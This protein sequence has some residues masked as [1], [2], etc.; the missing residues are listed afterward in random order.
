MTEN[1]ITDHWGSLETAEASNMPGLPNTSHA[2]VPSP[3][4]NDEAKYS[5][6]SPP[7]IIDLT[8]TNMEAPINQEVFLMT[9]R[10]SFHEDLLKVEDNDNFRFGHTSNL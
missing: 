10:E 7:R 2:A 5:K 3:N 6:R 4:W 9:G 8:K 1:S